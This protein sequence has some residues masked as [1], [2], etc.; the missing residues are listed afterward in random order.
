[1]ITKSN[2][3]VSVSSKLLEKFDQVKE[4]N[5]ISHLVE[6]WL[7]DFVENKKK[8]VPKNNLPHGKRSLDKTPSQERRS[9]S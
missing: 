8:G 2:L 5:K 9:L 6:S 4:N 7:I 3:T 1:M